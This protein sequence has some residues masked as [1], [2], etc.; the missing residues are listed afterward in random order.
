M[1]TYKELKV[2]RDKL[3]S[4]E[5][6]LEAA[7]AQ[8]WKNFKEGQKSWHTKD[9]K[10]RRSKVLKEKCEICGS[11]DTLTIQHLSASHTMSATLLSGSTSICKVLPFLVATTPTEGS[12]G[13]VTGSISIKLNSTEP[14]R[15]K[16]K[17]NT[18]AIQPSMVIAQ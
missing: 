13:S 11:K 1:L 2:L 5:I 18:S 10:E 7:E 4:G 6:N 3:E 14:V 16:L 17:T 8:Y 12:D 15:F 9:W